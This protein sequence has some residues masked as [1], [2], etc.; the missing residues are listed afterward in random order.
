MSWVI[1]NRFWYNKRHLYFAGGLEHDA[2]MYE[3]WLVGVADGTRHKKVLSVSQS[4]GNAIGIR[5]FRVSDR[6]M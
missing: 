1:L 3:Q 6:D 5:L 4:Y 2:D